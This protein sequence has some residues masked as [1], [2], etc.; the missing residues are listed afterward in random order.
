MGWD[1]K[2]MLTNLFSFHVETYLLKTYLVRLLEYKS[3]RAR[4]DL[5]PGPPAP[6]AGVIIRT[7]RR[8]PNKGL[9]YKYETEIIKTLLTLR[10][11]GLKEGTLSS[12][13]YQQKYLG[14]K[15]KPDEP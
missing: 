10:S 6:Q 13:N 9:C 7:R 8:A 4:W 2:S 3:W 14:Q 5:N 12:V 15:R 1:Q 11:N